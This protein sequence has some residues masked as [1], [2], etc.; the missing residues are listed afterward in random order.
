MAFDRNKDGKVTRDELPERMHG[1]IARGDTNNDGALDRDEIRELASTPAGP[2]PLGFG[3]KRRV[4]PGPVTAAGGFR[5]GPVGPGGGFRVDFGSGP[6]DIQG[7]VDDLRL[8]GQKKGRAEAAVKAHQENVRKLMDQA[9]AE[10]LQQ[11]KEIL[12]AEEWNDFKAAL[13]RPR[14]G[15]VFID[16]GPAGVP[17]PGG[18]ERKLDPRQEDRGN[19]KR[20]RRR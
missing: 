13:G 7:V 8:S 5:A 18:L 9:R 12:S 15:R 1:L 20:E 10:L 4:G 11:M 3:V 19:L 2:G 6:G 14:G 17:R 16:V